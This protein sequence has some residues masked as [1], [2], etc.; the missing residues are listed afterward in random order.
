MSKIALL[1]P[2]QG[3]QTLGMGSS[4]YQYPWVQELYHNAKHILGYDIYELCQN[5]ED[6]LHQT[7]YAQ[8]A[9][10]TT[11]LAIFETF[12]RLTKL[13]IQAM[14]GFSL[15]EYSALAA[16]GVFTNEA[17]MELVHHR[18][19]LMHEASLNHPGQMAAVLG[20]NVADLN[21]LC[22]DI[23]NIS[24]ANINSYDQLVV[25]GT[26]EA[27][28]KLQ[29]LAKQRGAKRVV[30]LKVSGAFHSP[31]MEEA[32]LQFAPFVARTT[33]KYPLC[34]IIMNTTGATL[35]FETLKQEMIKQITSPVQFVKSV[36]TMVEM[37]IDTFIE[38]GPGSVLSG[39]VRKMNPNL[40]LYQINHPADITQIM[41]ELV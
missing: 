26:T 20:M 23:G 34:D 38:I 36:E 29:E 30:V 7:L 17:T 3:A 14:C 2:G 32:A 28:A 6:A 9:I 39:L 37:G 13:P 22:G 16:S 35:I 31:L 1:F 10:L 15:G 18:S 33:P 24:V 5:D 19:R 40:R 12:K 11:S 4:F 41:E 25:S 21:G 8:N 27:M